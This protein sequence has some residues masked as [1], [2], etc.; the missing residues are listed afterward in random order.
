MLTKQYSFYKDCCGTIVWKRQALDIKILGGDTSG[1]SG[2]QVIVPGNMPG[3]VVVK[4]GE[5]LTHGRIFHNDYLRYCLLFGC[6]STAAIEIE[7][8]HERVSE[9]QIPFFC[10][11]LGPFAVEAKNEAIIGQLEPHCYFLKTCPWSWWLPLCMELGVTDDKMTERYRIVRKPC[12]CYCCTHWDIN[13]R[14]GR[15]QG[16]INQ[17]GLFC[18]N[19]EITLPE[20]N[21]QMRIMCLSAMGALP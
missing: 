2:Q 1:G 8:N 7:M 11:C 21:N 12:T 18:P 17:V 16:E 10:P 9:A 6:P 19:Y 14:Q 15:P 3:A 20:D 5:T 13:D 4:G